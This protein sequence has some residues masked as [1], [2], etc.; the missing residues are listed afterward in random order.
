MKCVI[1]FSSLDGIKINKKAECFSILC[2]YHP[3]KV[4]ED[5]HMKVI[6]TIGIVLSL[7]VIAASAQVQIPAQ[8]LE[9]AFV[10]TPEE[11]E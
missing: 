1:L 10:L 8:R 6:L 9:E 5:K 3:E 7:L 11:Q 2:D 4:E